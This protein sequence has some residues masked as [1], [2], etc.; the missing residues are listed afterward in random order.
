MDENRKS[1]LQREANARLAL[2]RQRVRLLRQRCI[3]GSLICFALLWGVVF[4]QLVSGN[5]PVLTGKGRSRD[6]NPSTSSTSGT[7]AVIRGDAEQLEIEA[8]EAEGAEAEALELEAAEIE[9][10]ELEA[11][12]LE[13][14]QNE[15]EPEEEL[16]T[17]PS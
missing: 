13:A 12:E 10:S 4:T 17:S 11:A 6:A 7:A 1:D 9:L 2:Q 3:A 5:D 8:A 16:T 15:P 14:A